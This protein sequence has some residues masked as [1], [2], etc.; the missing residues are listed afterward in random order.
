MCLTLPSFLNSTLISEFEDLESHSLFQLSPC[1]FT[2][3]QLLL[4]HFS[5]LQ[6][7]HYTSFRAWLK[8]QLP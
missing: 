2:P 1:L 4:R 3:S 7:K 6:S 8:Y 5:L